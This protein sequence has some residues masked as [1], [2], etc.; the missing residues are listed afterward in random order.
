MTPKSLA[1]AL[2]LALSGCR[3]EP[4]ALTREEADVLSAAVVD[5]AASHPDLKRELRHLRRT[6]RKGT[7][8]ELLMATSQIRNTAGTTI[9]DALELVLEQ[10]EAAARQA[11]RKK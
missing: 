2:V 4:A 5:I 7:P 9:D 11:R 10:A 8:E 3:T 1:F 6:L